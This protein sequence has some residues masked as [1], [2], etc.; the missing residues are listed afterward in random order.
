[1]NKEGIYIAKKVINH[2]T[3]SDDWVKISKTRHNNNKKS[4]SYEDNL[5][6]KLERKKKNYVYK[7]TKN[8]KELEKYV[9][10]NSIFIKN[11]LAEGYIITNQDLK[12][13]INTKLDNLENKLDLISTCNNLREFLVLRNDV[14]DCI[15]FINIKINKDNFTKLILDNKISNKDGEIIN[16]IKN[17]LN[18]SKK[19]VPKVWKKIEPGLSFADILKQ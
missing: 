2:N 16:K 14:K 19:T 6:K 13:E 7:I 5:K 1:M 8:K 18:V 3:D 15:T 17:N 11:R 12:R 10:E 9:A 4:Y